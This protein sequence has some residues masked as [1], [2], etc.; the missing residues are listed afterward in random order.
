MNEKIIVVAIVTAAVVYFV[1][2]VRRSVKTGKC[3]GCAGDCK[4]EKV[5]TGSKANSIEELPACCRAAQ[6]KTRQKA[7][8]K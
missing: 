2:M 7:E 4:T 8:N 6:E 3:A 1:R 5:F